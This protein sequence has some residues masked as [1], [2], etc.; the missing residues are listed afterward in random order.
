METKTH[1]KKVFNKDYLGS[2]DLEDGKDLKAIIKNVEIRDVKSPQGKTEKRNVAVFTDAKIKPMILNVTNCKVIKKFAKTNF[3]EDWTNIAVQI[4]VKGDVQAFGDVTE[5]LRIREQQ[6]AV[7][8]PKLIPTI[9]QWQKAIVYLKSDGSTMDRIKR[10][11]D[12]SPEHEQQLKDAV[13][14]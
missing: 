9:D 3:I 4:Y 5:G 7:S 12:L 14:S 10:D 2:C 6:P 8:K 1:W 11:W 13:L